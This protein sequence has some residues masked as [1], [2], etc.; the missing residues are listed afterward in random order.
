MSTIVPKISIPNT[1]IKA[2]FVNGILNSKEPAKKAAESIDEIVRCPT[3][4]FYNDS[5]DD[6]TRT[7]KDIFKS[8]LA[9]L[10]SNA[11]GLYTALISSARSQLEVNQRKEK[12]AQKLA[13]EIK[14]FLNTHPYNHLMLIGHGQGRDICAETLPLLLKKHRDKT[15][16]ITLGSA[17]IDP[18][19]AKEVKTINHTNDLVPLTMTVRDMAT[20]RRQYQQANVEQIEGRENV[21]TSHTFQ[22]YM[23]YEEVVNTIQSTEEK[24][25]TTIKRKVESQ[26]LSTEEDTYSTRTSKRIRRIN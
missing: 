4:S 24:I 18:N 13:H 6:V 22:N 16:V 11:F 12:R 5:S 9:G 20:N 14:N 7:L 1:H 26:S 3:E 21:L 23:E 19:A 10:F 8:A 17:P 25:I 2:I 15:Y